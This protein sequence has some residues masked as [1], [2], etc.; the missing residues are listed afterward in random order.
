MYFDAF[1]SGLNEIGT[2]QITEAENPRD[3]HKSNVLFGAIRTLKVCLDFGHN[4][5]PS[6]SKE[7]MQILV[8]E[9]NG[10]AITHLQPTNENA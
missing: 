3:W 9:W 10:Q 6:S 1:I 8:N 2:R 7:K 4:A 5:I